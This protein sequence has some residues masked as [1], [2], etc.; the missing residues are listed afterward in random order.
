MK[1]KCPSNCDETRHPFDTEKPVTKM[2]CLINSPLKKCTQ[3]VEPQL[4]PGVTNI[5]SVCLK[6]NGKPIHNKENTPHDRTLDLELEPFED[7]GY[8]SLQNSQVEDLDNVREFGKSPEHERVSPCIPVA[9][10]ENERHTSS[11]LP[12][13]KFQHAVCQELAKSFRRTKNYDWTAVSQLAENFGLEKVIGRKIGLE[14]VDVFKALFERDMKHI[15]TRILHML[16]DVDL[17][18]CREVSKSWRRIICQNN[19]ALRRCH[20]AEQRIRDSKSVGLENVDSLTRDA[21]LSRVV[22][23][24]VQRVASPPTQSS[25]KKLVSRQSRFKQYLEAASSLKQCESLKRCMRCSSPAKYD[26]GATRAICT[27]LSCAFDF[28]TQCLGPFHRSSPCHVVPT[29]SPGSSRATPILIG[30]TRS[31]RNVRRL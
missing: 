30:S 14:Y 25:T 5:A 24:C 18:S 15:L 16:G 20:Q 9:D 11:T 23:S 19:S 22:M 17:I 10:N 29:R 12:I 3:G 7:S 27:R 2:P 28:C 21:T 26:E 31:K 6:D 13:L 4:S 1:M 8:L